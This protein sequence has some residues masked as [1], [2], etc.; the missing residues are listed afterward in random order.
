MGGT[1]GQREGRSTPHHQI[2]DPATGARAAGRHLGNDISLLHV[3]PDCGL[4]YDC[5]AP[6][7]ANVPAI[8][9]GGGVKRSRCAEGQGAKRRSVCGL[10]CGVGML[11]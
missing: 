5:L 10:L 2:A 1:G 7:A 8:H 11:P 9:D 6:M 4:L 3:L